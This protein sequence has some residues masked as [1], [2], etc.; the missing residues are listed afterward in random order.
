MAGRLFTP[1]VRISVVVVLGLTLSACGGGLFTKA[2]P[3]AY[4]LTA[5][6]QFPRWQGAPR[7]QLV[8][9]EPSGVSALDTEKVVVRST[10]GEISTLPGAQWSDRLPKLLQS[11]IVQ[12]FE[13]ANRLRAVGKP[14]ERLTVD[15]QLLVDLRAFQIA[16]G[17]GTSAEVEFTAKIVADRSGRIVAAKVFRVSIPVGGTAAEPSMAALDDAFRRA[18]TEL[19]LWASRIV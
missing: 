15:Y 8:V 2:P 5:A 12:S 4:D 6:R 9:T 14:G 18:V 16:V 7:G 10:Q 19:V 13:N 1:S 17:D 11:R 3:P